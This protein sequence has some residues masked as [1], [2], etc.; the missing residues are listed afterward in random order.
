MAI[1]L[2]FDLL[3]GRAMAVE[4][5]RDTSCCCAPGAALDKIGVLLRR[6]APGFV[7]LF[8]WYAVVKPGEA[9]E[10]ETYEVWALAGAGALLGIL[11]YALHRCF[12]SRCILQPLIMRCHLGHGERSWVSAAQKK[13]GKADIGRLLLE[14]DAERLRRRI[15]EDVETRAVQRGLDRWRAIQS[16]LYCSSYALIVVGLL[17]EYEYAG[18]ETTIWT[19]FIL[20]LGGVALVGALISNYKLMWRDLWAAST[21]PQ[22]KKPTSTGRRRKTS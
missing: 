1:L 22:A 21:Y 15:S 19:D 10:K 3:K 20:I 7:A 6:V 17:G 8:A 13:L 14:L 4:K 18:L 16:F 2:G 12:I 11:I 9:T 5:I